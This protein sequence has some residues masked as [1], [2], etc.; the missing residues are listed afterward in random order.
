MTTQQELQKIANQV[1]GKV[2]N[3]TGLN[4]RR[5]LL[6]TAV[7]EAGF[8]VIGED[9]KPHRGAAFFVKEMADKTFRINYRCGYSQWNYA[10]VLIVTT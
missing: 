6:T 3:K 4:Q 8:K 7:T 9:E 2:H 5:K 1:A 10:P